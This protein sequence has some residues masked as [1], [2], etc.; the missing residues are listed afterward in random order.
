MLTPGRIGAGALVAAAIY[1]VWSSGVKKKV[2]IC[3]DHTE[4][5]NYTR[6]LEAWDANSSFQFEFDNR[7]PSLPGR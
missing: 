5:A 2:F 4:D 7:S 1:W 6:L 3:C